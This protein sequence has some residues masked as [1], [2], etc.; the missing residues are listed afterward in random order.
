VSVLQTTLS[1]VRSIAVNSGDRQV[2]HTF[3]DRK[4][5]DA[6][7]RVTCEWTN[8]T[9]EQQ[10][11]ERYS[12]S[13]SS[14]S[15]VLFPVALQDL[16]MESYFQYSRR[17]RKEDWLGF[18]QALAQNEGMTDLTLLNADPITDENWT[19]LWQSVS[20]HPK[21]E[22]I[23]FPFLGHLFP[24]TCSD[25]QK[26]LRT[27]AIV[28]ALR[29][30]TVMLL[31]IDLYPEEFDKVLLDNHVYPRLLANKYRSRVA[32]IAKL[33]GEWRR[34]LLLRALASVASNPNLILMFVSGN[35]N[36]LFPPRHASERSAK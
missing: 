19:A 20:R 18:F 26:T 5:G 6:E 36:G 3:E 2:H 25:A 7:G 8:Q 31:D 17:L 28:D 34:Q 14:R 13:S 22:R 1:K 11:S 27:Q 24:T 4:L 21:L 16:T 30:N 15:S 35:V 10:N 29:I 23:V 32:A 12:Y 33:E 9:S